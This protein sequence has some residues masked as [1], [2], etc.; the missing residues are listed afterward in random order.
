MEYDELSEEELEKIENYFNNIKKIQIFQSEGVAILS[1]EGKFSIRNKSLCLFCH[2][3]VCFDFRFHSNRLTKAHDDRVYSF[4]RSFLGN[5]YKE[6]IRRIVKGAILY[7]K[8]WKKLKERYRNN[9]DIAIAPDS[10][11][12]II[13]EF[14][15][16]KVKPNCLFFWKKGLGTWLRKAIENYQE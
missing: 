6:R 16:S 8:G 9:R 7:D 5:P 11:E 2:L 12:E 3:A 14:Y 4:E 15:K 13:E 1:R 10:G